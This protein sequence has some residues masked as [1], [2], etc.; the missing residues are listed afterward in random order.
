MSDR[1]LPA[2]PDLERAVLGAMMNFPGVIPDVV[3]VLRP[4][5]FWTPAHKNLYRAVVWLHDRGEPVDKYSVVESLTQMGKLDEAGGA[6]GIVSITDEIATASNAKHHTDIL[7]GYWVRRSIIQKSEQLQS[8][9]FDDT[10]GSN[11]R[12]FIRFEIPGPLSMTQIETKPS[13]P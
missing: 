5:A 3:E 13:A 11:S 9:A 2:N 12:S 1:L 8:R 4:A 10:N 6:A 7:R